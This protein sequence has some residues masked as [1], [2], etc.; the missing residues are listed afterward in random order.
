MDKTSLTFN[1][2]YDCIGGIHPGIYKKIDK[3]YMIFKDGQGYIDVTE[4]VNF[5]ASLPKNKIIPF[6]IQDMSNIFDSAIITI[7][8]FMSTVLPE[9]LGTLPNDNNIKDILDKR[10]PFV[11]IKLERD[12]WAAIL[13]IGYFQ[14][15]YEIQPE[16]YIYN[17][18]PSYVCYKSSSLGIR[19]AIF[20]NQ[21]L[22]FFNVN[23]PTIICSQG[24]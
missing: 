6:S 14:F 21:G 16:F 15:L 24:Q 22:A 1:V 4:T 9:K 20:A 17:R 3:Y 2:L 13:P 12:T 5:D 10:P 19:G 11:R 7:E 18:T 23:Y 8:K